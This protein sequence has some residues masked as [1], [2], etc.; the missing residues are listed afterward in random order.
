VVGI[1]IEDISNK[2]KLGHHPKGSK[3]INQWY[4]PL[5]V[6]YLSEQKVL[7][8]HFNQKIQLTKFPKFSGYTE[9]FTKISLNEKS[10]LTSIGNFIELQM[11]TFLN[12]QANNGFDNSK[13]SWDEIYVKYLL[14]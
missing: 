14:R 4:M 10:L 11:T 12:L 8:S 13:K 3:I 2:E 9:V 6:C 7:K 1:T 5:A